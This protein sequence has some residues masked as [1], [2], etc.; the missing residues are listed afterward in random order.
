MR[1]KS[2]GPRINESLDDSR[3]IKADNLYMPSIIKMLQLDRD[4]WRLK[5]FE[6]EKQTQK[7]KNK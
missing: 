7:L 1:S 6:L 2:V 4:N 3:I 5:H